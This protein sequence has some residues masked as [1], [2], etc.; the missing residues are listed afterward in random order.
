MQYWKTPYNFYWCLTV[1]TVSHHSKH[2]EEI[3]CRI[4][5]TDELGILYTLY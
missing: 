3:F 2:K 5:V 4:R 1:I